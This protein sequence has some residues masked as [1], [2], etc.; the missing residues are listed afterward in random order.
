MIGTLFYF[1]CTML[2]K[3]LIHQHFETLRSRLA[4]KKIPSPASLTVSPTA[5]LDSGHTGHAVI[6]RSQVLS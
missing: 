1:S 4:E 2:G 6:S 5:T 3:E